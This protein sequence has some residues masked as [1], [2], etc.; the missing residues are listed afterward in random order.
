MLNKFLCSVAVAATF[1]LVVP[2]VDAKAATISGFYSLNGGAIT[3]LGDLNPNPDQFVFFGALGNFTINI[4]SG[5]TQ[6]SSNPN[7]L[8]VQAQD[9]HT[10]AGN[11]TLRLFFVATGLTPGGPQTFHSQFT[12]NATGS[13]L[14]VTERTY[15][16]TESAPGLLLGSA[17]FP[18]LLGTGASSTFANVPAGYSLTGEIFINATGVQSSNAT[19]TVSA[20][21]GP[22]VGAGLPGLIAAC[23]GLLALARRRRKQAA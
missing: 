23:G 1:A 14:V 11:D 19:I 10:T 12:S 17:T 3:A 2:V 21:P 22:I 18:P 7:L 20:V 6:P 9:G 13:G 8:S 16:G 5:T 4:D 15:L